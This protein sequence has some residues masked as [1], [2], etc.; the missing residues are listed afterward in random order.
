MGDITYKVT[1][2]ANFQIN[3]K[4]RIFNL[5]DAVIKNDRAIQSVL[6]R[7]ILN[8]SSVYLASWKVVESH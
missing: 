4:L 1:G 6:Q 2:F 7:N 3:D 8:N 5:D